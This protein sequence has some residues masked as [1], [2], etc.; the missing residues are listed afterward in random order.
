MKSP[1]HNL[2]WWYCLGRGVLWPSNGSTRQR[3]T[4]P[5]SNAAQCKCLQVFSHRV[6]LTRDG[7]LGQDRETYVGLL[8]Q[9]CSMILAKRPRHS[10]CFTTTTD[11]ILRQQLRMYSNNRIRMYSH[12]DRS[13]FARRV[14][15]ASQ[16]GLDTSMANSAEL[17]E[18]IAGSLPT[19]RTWE[20]A[21][22]VCAL[23]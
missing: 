15:K 19:S 22:V 23:G 3:G 7:A 17:R 20:R 12:L 16:I 21:H 1:I 18:G 10:G 14:S 8:S 5:S 6:L 4:E 11:H 13:R 9:C 2:V